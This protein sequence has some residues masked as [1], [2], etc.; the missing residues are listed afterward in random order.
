M[1]ILRQNKK[2]HPIISIPNFL[3]DFEINKIF[4]LPKFK[5]L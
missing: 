5:Y 3:S 2:L 4:D 1:N